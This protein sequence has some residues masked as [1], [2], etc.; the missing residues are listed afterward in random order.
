[1]KQI[2]TPTQLHNKW[3]KGTKWASSRLHV[4]RER[5]A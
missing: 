1:M 3:A 2:L 5:I 4:N